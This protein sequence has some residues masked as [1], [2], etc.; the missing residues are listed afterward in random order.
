MSVGDW[1]R[2]SYLGELYHSPKFNFWMLNKLWWHYYSKGLSPPS[3]AREGRGGGCQS[4]NSRYRLCY[5]GCSNI[6]F[7]VVLGAGGLGPASPQALGACLDSCGLCL[8]SKAMSF[9]TMPKQQGDSIHDWG[10]YQDAILQVCKCIIIHLFVAL[11]YH[12]LWL[13]PSESTVQNI[14][15]LRIKQ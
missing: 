6:L 4:Y 5:L 8:K 2:F 7:K 13:T 11:A 1:T 9:L 12:T 15:A 14:S 3:C 10:Y